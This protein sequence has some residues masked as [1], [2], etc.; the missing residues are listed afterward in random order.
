MPIERGDTR[1]SQ[2]STA[3]IAIDMTEQFSEFQG[4]AVGALDI[5]WLH[6]L[7][8]SQSAVYTVRSSEF[9]PMISLILLVRKGACIRPQ[10]PKT[11]NLGSQC[12]WQ[13]D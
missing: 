11:T 5:R 10:N 1:D 4:Y 8:G 3:P 7:E 6:Y 12:R 2:L 13:T 9:P